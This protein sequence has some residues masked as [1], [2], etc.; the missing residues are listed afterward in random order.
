MFLLLLFSRSVVSDSLQ[1]RGLYV[2]RQ[3][4]LSTGF[5]RQ[6]YWSGLPFPSPYY[7]PGTLLSV[8]H[9]LYFTEFS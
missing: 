6:E 1:P 9:L 5:S 3:V 2:A 8:G 4:P 7:V